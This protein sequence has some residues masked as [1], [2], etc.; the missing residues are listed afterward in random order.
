LV[1]EGIYY[2]HGKSDAYIY[3]HDI[4][5]VKNLDHKLKCGFQNW[6][7]NYYYYFKEI[8]KKKLVKWKKMIVFCQAAHSHAFCLVIS[9]ISNCEESNHLLL[10]MYN[11]AISALNLFFTFYFL[12]HSENLF[13]KYQCWVDTTIGI[14]SFLEL[15]FR[16]V[17][18]SFKKKKKLK[19]KE[20]FKVL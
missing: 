10:I 11:P 2:V 20:P 1:H 15:S 9:K 5:M 13:G 14:N 12:E 17:S 8:N 19:I 3:W 6:L 4:H 7:S 16:L 18:F